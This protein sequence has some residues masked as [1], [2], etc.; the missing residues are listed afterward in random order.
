MIAQHEVS[1]DLKIQV[2][3]DQFR[4]SRRFVGEITEMQ[5]KFRAAV[6][7]PCRKMTMLLTYFNSLSF[8]ITRSKT[9]ELIPTVSGNTEGKLF[10]AFS[11]VSI[12]S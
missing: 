12:V 10:M 4:C 1:G 5:Q 7:R 3:P 11:I 6:D 9:S 2:L 8:F